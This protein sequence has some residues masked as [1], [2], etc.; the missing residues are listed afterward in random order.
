MDFAHIRKKPRL[1]TN[2]SL[3]SLA[4]IMTSSNND[5]LISNIPTYISSE[6]LKIFITSSVKH[7]VKIID[8]NIQ[9][10]VQYARVSFES[11]DQANLAI[12][13]LNGAFIEGFQLRVQPW[14]FNLL[15]AQQHTTSSSSTIKWKFQVL[16]EDN[17]IFIRKVPPLTTN[18]ELK[19]F[20]QRRI[21]VAFK[22]LSSDIVILT[23]HVFKEGNQAFVEFQ[24]KRHALHALALKNTNINGSPLD[25]LSWQN[26]QPLH[27]RDDEEGLLSEDR[28]QK[29]EPRQPDHSFAVYVSN[30]PNGATNVRLKSF[31]SEMMVIAYKESPTIVACSVR[32][33]PRKDAYVEFQNEEQV[34]RA[35]HLRNR[36]FDGHLLRIIPW[37]PTFKILCFEDDNLSDSGKSFNSCTDRPST[38]T[39]L[40]QPSSLIPASH[41]GN[42]D[43]E[44]ALKSIL[45][46]LSTEN[47]TKKYIGET[48]DSSY[49]TDSFE[50][51][52]S[53]SDTKSNFVRE[54]A[55]NIFKRQ[56]DALRL[57][58]DRWKAAYNESQQ[59][60]GQ[61]SAEL[62]ST[63][64]KY[65]ALQ[66]QYGNLQNQ[67]RV[68]PFVPS[69]N[70]PT[71]NEASGE[72]KRRSFPVTL[73]PEHD[74]GSIGQQSNHTLPNSSMYNRDW[75]G[76]G[77]ENNK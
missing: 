1:D 76:T 15:P 9:S 45:I 55:A 5:V 18:E 48:K 72:I 41:G 61:V 35:V 40:L 62:A 70:L 77:F 51:T 75:F 68:R 38:S 24:S 21:Q 36:T 10:D 34:Y 49:L 57:D 29:S 7:Q 56:M 74:H 69:V 50:K 71:L 37:D 16:R 31:L 53:I 64:A 11:E 47:T 66:Q 59:N 65:E 30:I 8:C 3:L 20:L 46:G 58:R 25:I 6:S 39:Q 17:A 44:Q 12:S 54:A 27:S 33:H 28:S 60:L 42:K 52:S 19:I 63:R 73:L 22:E 26:R 4:S 14:S 32:L 13:S 2:H 43:P 67:A 23:C